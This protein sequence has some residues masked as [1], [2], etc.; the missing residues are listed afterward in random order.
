METTGRLM[1]LWTVAHRRCVLCSVDHMLEVR[2]YDH[3]LLVALQLCKTSH[4]AVA[5]AREW[6]V[7]PPVWPPF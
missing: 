7:T 5:V 1:E 4:D 6:R 2:L 3:G